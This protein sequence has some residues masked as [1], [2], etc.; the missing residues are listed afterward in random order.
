M[1]HNETIAGTA[2]SDRLNSL[3]FEQEGSTLRNI[4]FFRG[5]RDVVTPAEIKAAMHSAIFAKRTGL[6]KGSA[7]FPDV[8]RTPVEARDLVKN[9]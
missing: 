7:S 5:T 4:K 8:D 3:L 9:L 6:V 1:G 2:E